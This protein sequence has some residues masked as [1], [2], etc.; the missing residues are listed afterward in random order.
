MELEDDDEI[1]DDINEDS[2]EVCYIISRLDKERYF[3]N[4]L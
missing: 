1:T 3:L 2:V 4:Y